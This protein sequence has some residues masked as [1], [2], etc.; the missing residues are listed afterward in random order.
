[1]RGNSRSRSRITAAPII[2]SAASING[3]LIIVMLKLLFG[4][5]GT[6]ESVAQLGKN[7]IRVMVKI[8]RNA[9]APFT[10]S[11]FCKSAYPVASFFN[12]LRVSQR[13]FIFRHILPP[14]ICAKNLARCRCNAVTPQSVHPTPFIHFPYSI[15]TKPP[16]HPFIATKV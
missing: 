11:R 13:A 12:K 2:T 8:N 7:H 16:R 14:L 4:V 3:L 10:P 5:F 9:Q 15:T 6:F 1:M